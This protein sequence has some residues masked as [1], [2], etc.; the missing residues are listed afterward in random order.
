MNTKYRANIDD[1][2]QKEFSIV[3]EEYNDPLFVAEDAAVDAWSG[4]TRDYRRRWFEGGM[5]IVVTRDDEVWRYHATVHGV[6]EFE[7][8]EVTK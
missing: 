3:D 6:P 5:D 7:I 1:G 2:P 8:K 4:G